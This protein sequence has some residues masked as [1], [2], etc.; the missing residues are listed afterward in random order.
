MHDDEA[1]TSPITK[2]EKKPTEPLTAKFEWN[3]PSRERSRPSVITKANKPMSAKNEGRR[4]L[5]GAAFELF[6]HCIYANSV[7]NKENPVRAIA[8]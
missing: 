3:K 1:A 7:K 4:S 2:A 6:V 5:G 8:T